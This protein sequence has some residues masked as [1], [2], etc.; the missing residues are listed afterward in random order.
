VGRVVDRYEPVEELE[1]GE[2]RVDDGSLPDRRIERELHVV[3]RFDVLAPRLTGMEGRA[4][5]PGPPGDP[6]GCERRAARSSGRI[7]SHTR[8]DGRQTGNVYIGPHR[9]PGAASLSSGG[10]HGAQSRS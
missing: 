5:A 10:R 9:S 2:E 8:N 1:L 7:V 3:D 6:Y 4:S